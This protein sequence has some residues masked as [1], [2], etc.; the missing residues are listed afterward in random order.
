MAEE[1]SGKYGN[2]NV[3]FFGSSR[4]NSIVISGRI[5][6]GNRE[7]GETTR[8]FTKA[9]DGSWSVHH[10]YLRLND[11]AQGGGFSN[12]YYDELM[13][14][15]RRSG[16]THIDIQAALSRG[17]YAWARRR[18]TWDPNQSMS[19]SVSNIR[20]RM[21]QA[22]DG[23]LQRIDQATGNFTT[24]PPLSASDRLKVEAMMARMTN[25]NNP[26]LPTPHEISNMSGDATDPTP[27]PGRAPRANGLGV[28][29]MQGSNW[30]GILKL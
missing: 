25:I 11:D 6:D 20:A 12:A 3:R 26:R 17:G 19:Y 10:D 30:Y 29:I 22:L 24:D 28:R 9:F 8:T 15:Y 13:A 27:P 16:L 21:Q 5:Y 23:V 14:Y 7:V 1:L 4:S 18:F 2:Y